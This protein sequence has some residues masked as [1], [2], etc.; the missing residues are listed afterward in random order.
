MKQT[1]RLK[2]LLKS[3]ELLVHPGVYDCLTARIAETVGFSMVKLLG[4]VTC[5]SLL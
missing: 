2:E 3:G 1:T 4:N 5:G